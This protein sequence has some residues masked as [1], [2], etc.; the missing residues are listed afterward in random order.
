[1]D[2]G[3]DLII[4]HVIFL[5]VFLFALGMVSGKLASILKVPDVALFLV[6]GIAV[7]QGLHLVTETSSSF[8]NQFILTIG[9]ALILFDG[10]RNI[11]LSGLRKVWVTLTL[12][13]VP[14]VL[15]TSCIVAAA[16]HY[17]L[18]LPWL[19]AMLLGAVISSTDPATIIPVFRQVRIREKVR[20]T[21]ES[22]SAFNDATGS[23]LTFS[24]MAVILGTEKVTV[25]GA[26]VDFFK[27]AAGGI[28]IGLAIGFLMTYLVA[29]GGSAFCGIIRRSRWSLRLW[30]LICSGSSLG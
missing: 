5:L 23:I 20:E 24:I 28:L 30:A 22:E 14:G 16:S 25:A 17:V 10:G 3:T 26:V 12:L 21:V 2:N 6:A 27:S 1:L 18:G 11:R 4:H 29:L 7:G 19:Y 8:T 13:S 9:S 15:I